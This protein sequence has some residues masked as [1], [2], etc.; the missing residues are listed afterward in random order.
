V[1]SKTLCALRSF[2]K[3]CVWIYHQM[4]WN[5][6]IIFL[7]KSSSRKSLVW[8]PNIVDC[9]TLYIQTAVCLYEYSCLLEWSDD[10][11]PKRMTMR[12][13]ICSRTAVFGRPM[14]IWS[15]LLSNPAKVWHDGIPSIINLM[16]MMVQSINPTYGR[17][18]G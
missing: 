15:G 10:R 5:F 12:N 7:S 1:V 9:I 13:N 4:I 14:V 18:S 17:L 11:L 16:M 8:R 6:V 2:S 3:N